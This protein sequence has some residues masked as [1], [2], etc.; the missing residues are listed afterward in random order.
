MIAKYGIEICYP[1]TMINIPKLIVA[2][3]ITVIQGYKEIVINNNENTNLVDSHI[4]LRRNQKFN[5]KV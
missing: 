4:A 1:I 2:Q 5:S 3:K